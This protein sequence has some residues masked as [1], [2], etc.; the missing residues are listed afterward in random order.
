[1][2]GQRLTTLAVIAMLLLPESSGAWNATGHQLVAR[3]AW[4][5]M[6]TATRRNVIALLRAAPADAC[7]LDLSSSDSRPLDARQ[8]EFF[9][10]VSTWPDIVRPKEEDARPCIRFHRRSWHFIN[11][12]WEGTSGATGD[13]RPKDREDIEIPEVNAVERLTLFRPLAV[14]GATPCGTEQE[15]RATTLA[16]IVHLVGDIHQPLHTSARVTSRPDER[17]GDQGGNLFKLD[18]SSAPLSLHGYWDGV[19][20]R[21]IPQQPAESQLAYLDRVAARIVAKHPPV[22]MSGRLRPGD[23]VAWSREGLETTKRAVYPRTLRRGQPPGDTYQARAL[24]I[25]E[26]AIAIAG[27]RLGDLLNRMFDSP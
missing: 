22:Q 3:I 14:C 6:T 4:D 16:W 11:Y 27:Y 26:E 17:E 24:A 1:M 20:D 7:L 2:T 8:R 12:F 10:L 5:Q 18:T 19:V 15:D 21:A 23:V 25:A 9:M 13:D